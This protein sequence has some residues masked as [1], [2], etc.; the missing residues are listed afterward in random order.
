MARC[1]CSGNTC[2]CKII[3]GGG[4]I[5]IGGAGTLGNPYTITGTPAVLAAIDT[6]SIDLTLVGD[7]TTSSPFVLT[8]ALIPLATTDLTN[9]AAV[10]P[11]AGQVPTWNA[12]TGKWTPGPA[13]TAT[14]GAIF[15][16]N[17][18]IGDGSSG[19]PLNLR[20]LSG[21]RLRT[22]TGG[23]DLTLETYARL[24][25]GFA[26]EAA[27]DTFLSTNSIA[28]ASGMVFY[29][30]GINAMTVYDGTAW[31]PIYTNV[32]KSWQ[33]DRP[34]SI[35]LYSAANT[36]LVSGTI[37]SARAGRYLMHS[38]ADLGSYGG[39]T[40]SNAMQL[41]NGATVI[42]SWQAD[43]NGWWAMCTSSTVYTHAGGTMNLVLR[44]SPSGGNQVR[45]AGTR[46]IAIFLGP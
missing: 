22:L 17:G 15:I 31:Q 36:G 14:P 16:G 20:P 41:V 30:A 26:T 9:W 11:T 40:L 7:G 19:S 24:N 29:I 39:A 33:F 28:A 6:A 23:S 3:A 45:A 32:G 44:S 5:I 46:I 27:R 25:L 10:A 42:D 21:G 38:Q 12:G 4:G 37:T 2:S 18:L 34:G 8:A 43:T 35:D 1:G 13:A